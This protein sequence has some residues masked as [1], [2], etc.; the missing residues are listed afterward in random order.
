MKKNRKGNF[1]KEIIGFILIS[2]IGIG[3]FIVISLNRSGE[4]EL[5]KNRQMLDMVET[6]VTNEIKDLSWEIAHLANTYAVRN[7][8][9]QL[10]TGDDYQVLNDRFSQEVD[11]F[12]GWNKGLRYVEME[13]SSDGIHKSLTWAGNKKS[14]YIQAL[15][16]QSYVDHQPGDYDIQL[17]GKEFQ[18]LLV[19]RVPLF[20]N[21]AFDGSYLTVAVELKEI[22]FDYYQKEDIFI[23]I[24][25]SDFK[26]YLYDREGRFD[27]HMKSHVLDSFSGQT[28]F[29]L[30]SSQDKGIVT[31][32]KSKEIFLTKAFADDYYIALIKPYNRLS[33][34]NIESNMYSHIL[35]YIL[36]AAGIMGYLMLSYEATKKWIEKD[37]TFL[38]EI[39]DLD[40]IQITEMK[41]EIKFHQ[42]THAESPLAILYV[43][44]QDLKVIRANQAAV[45]LFAYEGDQLIDRDLADLCRWDEDQDKGCLNMTYIRQDGERLNGYAKL[46]EVTFNGNDFIIL[47]LEMKDEGEDALVLD[48]QYELFH[49]IR[50]P[51][52]GAFGAV[53][54]IDRASSSYKDY[55]NL[56][57]RSLNSVLMLTENVLAKG[58]IKSSKEKILTNSFDLV[59]LLREVNQLIAYQD[60][61]HNQLISY[62]CLRD[63][64]PVKPL[65][66]LMIK[67]DRSKLKQILINLLANGSKYTE[68]G[69][70]TLKVEIEKVE[71]KVRALFS[72]KDTGMG[73]SPHD[74]EGLFQEFTT[75]HDNDKVTSSGIGLFIC[76]K[77]VDLLGGDLQVTSQE[78][79]GTEFT[80][81]LEL[82]LSQEEDGGLKYDFK[83][84][85]LDDDP[86][87]CSYLKHLLEKES[88]L[89]VS[90][91]NDE[92]LIMNELVTRNYDALLIDENLNHFKGGHIIEMIKGSC[93]KGISAMPIIL[94]SAD[95][96]K[97]GV[98]Y[99]VLVKPFDND[100][101]LDLI[102]GLRHKELLR[103][104]IDLEVINPDILCETYHSVGPE[105]FSTILDKFFSSSEGELLAI[106]AYVEG[107]DYKRAKERLHKLKGSIS[108]FGSRY[109]YKQIQDLESLCLQESPDLIQA[110][111]AFEGHFRDFL[112]ALRKLEGGLDQRDKGLIQ[113]N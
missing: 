31:N 15:D 69:K 38:N 56:I 112:L 60:K 75:F 92:T 40:K 54:L 109:C 64:H 107:R 88:K 59:G 11:V 94:M 101:V 45:D 77:Y 70:I 89:H 46:Q 110:Y 18:S 85:V 16:W 41:K 36:A 28:Y 61:H 22:L 83:V 39:I 55:T 26:T 29:S 71:G 20:E 57:K 8:K 81:E 62:A 105:V 100:Q 5:D 58:K 63:V 90:I 84:L 30:K 25:D 103:D 50:S 10:A 93:N 9:N 23:N 7:L 53:D 1:L 106:R 86:V 14:Q 65:E 43:N 99:P 47:Y 17:L 108:Y 96:A 111:G 27:N 67:G 72:V 3:L 104:F 42:A 33:L 34:K 76:K 24:I 97:P 19:M 35:I 79:L 4:N 2:I 51:L 91:M 113:V 49:E 102:Q 98:N 78:G 48:K 21:Q 82:D 44:K 87:S 32:Y 13:V 6:S 80:F 52:Q 74:L 73:M 66:R 68:D 37:R 95:P 12:F